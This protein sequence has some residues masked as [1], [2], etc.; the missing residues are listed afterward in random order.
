M[1]ELEFDIRIKS[2]DLYDYKLYHTYHG[3]QGLLGACLGALAV[4]V[5]L[6]NRQVVYLIA[7]F[8]IL[9]YLPW[10]LYLKSK[11]QVLTN[12][13][14][15]NPLHY[16]IREEGIAVS[17]GENTEFQKWEDMHKAVSTGKSIIVYTN[18]VNA[19]IFPRRELG[20]R[21][22]AVIGM[23]STHMEPGKVNIRF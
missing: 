13:A 23:I 15:Q 16:V 7:G 21:V 19:C 12:P 22:E 6:G 1:N 8:A 4:L 14:F 2:S 17:Q 3:T 18:K 11:R 9:G 20:N 10:S 5:F